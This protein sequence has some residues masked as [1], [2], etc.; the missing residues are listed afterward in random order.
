MIKLIKIIYFIFLS[1]CFLFFQ[2]VNAQ[3]KIKIG[4]LV[5]MTGENK[6]I[7][8]LNGM[9]YISVRRAGMYLPKIKNIPGRRA[10]W[11]GRRPGRGAPEL[12]K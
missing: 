4:L 7:G 12:K 6:E 10:G 9:E 3:E 5:P 1:F 2:A 8:K 11:V